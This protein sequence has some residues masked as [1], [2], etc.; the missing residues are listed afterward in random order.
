MTVLLDR[1]FAAGMLN[2]VFVCGHMRSGSSLLVHILNTH[3][4][5][6]GYGESHLRYR[7]TEDFGN[8]ALKICS[9]LKKLPVGKYSMVDKVLHNHLLED[10][11]ILEEAKTVFLLRKPGPALSSMYRQNIHLF[12][13]PSDIARYYVERLE[14]IREASRKVDPSKWTWGTY[15]LLTRRTEV[16]FDRIVGL[17]DLPGGLTDTYDLLETTGKRGIGDNSDFIR[18]GKIVQKSERELAR[19]MEPYLEEAGEAFAACVAELGRG[20]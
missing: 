10:P 13:T 12:D 15:G 14:W 11:E 4:G 7:D 16:F 9:T 18:E 2:M 20:N 17:L 19:E 6:M 8:A 3:P 5:I 1:L